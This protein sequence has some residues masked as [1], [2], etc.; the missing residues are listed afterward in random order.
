M[1]NSSKG[2]TALDEL[3]AKIAEPVGAFNV[4]QVM[5][6]VLA[7]VVDKMIDDRVFILIVADV[8]E[9]AHIA[10]TSNMDPDGQFHLMSELMEQVS[11][12][13]EELTQDKEDDPPS[14]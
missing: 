12:K 2:K 10:Y 14:N 1:V 9:P 6:N 3:L 11:K 13:R 5:V 8:T 4:Y 7:P